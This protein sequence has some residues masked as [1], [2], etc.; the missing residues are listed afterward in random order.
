MS[1]GAGTVAASALV[2]EADEVDGCC[3]LE[4]ARPV[5]F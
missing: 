4:I 2:I 1:C 5:T 3:V